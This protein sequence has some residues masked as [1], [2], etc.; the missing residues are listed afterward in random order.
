MSNFRPP[1]CF[2]IKD[3]SM[4]FLLQIA[5]I[6]T[7]LGIISCGQNASSEQGNDNADT[8]MDTSATTNRSLTALPDTHTCALRGSILQGNQFWIREQQVLVAIVADSTTYAKDLEAEG[9]RI[10]EIYDTKDC[11]QILR[12]TLPV[13]QSPDFPYYIAEPTYNNVAQMVA[14]RGSTSIYVY[15]IANRRL[16]PKLTPKFQTKRESIDAQ[17]GMIQHLEMWENFM[18]GYSQDYG[19][20]VYNISNKQT[21][22]AVLPFGEYKIADG[23]FGSM[24]LL[25]SANGGVQGIVPQ[26]DR[27]TGEFSVNPI[28]DKPTNM[29]ATV[30][31]SA[32]NNRYLVLR[33]ANSNAIG[34]DLQTHKRIDLPAD[35]VTKPTQEVLT[36]MRKKK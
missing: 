25:A 29:D 28:L 35:V 1:I 31:K 36:W 24:F 23:D 9:H 15:D 22:E 7:C 8:G 20:F 18:V 6:V 10:L 3:H 32:K 5:L 21:P 11:S 4:R 16:L 14:V 12:Q 33:D 27:N 26:F 19:A 17:S 2:K 34:V 13:D 30:T